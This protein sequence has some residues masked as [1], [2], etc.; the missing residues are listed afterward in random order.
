MATATDI[1]D[2]IATTAAA[3]I[4]SATVDGQTVVALDLS[5]QIEA[6]RAVATSAELAN[7]NPQ[8]G[9]RSG[10]NALRPAKFVPPGC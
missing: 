2:N 7:E 6:Q 10:W 1:S 8:G 4:A 3:G 5:K 9:K